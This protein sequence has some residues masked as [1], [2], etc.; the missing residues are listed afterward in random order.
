MLN[1][2]RL[3]FGLDCLS[4]IQLVL[5]ISLCF[6]LNDGRAASDFR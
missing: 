5:I 3:N 2:K 4:A 1:F 6:S